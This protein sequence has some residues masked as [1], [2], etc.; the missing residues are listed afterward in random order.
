[1]DINCFKCDEPIEKW[2]DISA[3]ALANGTVMHEKCEGE[4][5]E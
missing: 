2:T 1:M 5:N 3:D 4:N